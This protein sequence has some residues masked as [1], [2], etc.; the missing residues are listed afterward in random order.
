[1]KYSNIGVKNEKIKC[2]Q[3]KHSFTNYRSDLV[4][5]S[6]AF[7]ASIRSKSSMRSFSISTA[8]CLQMSSMHSSKKRNRLDEINHRG[9][10]D[11]SLD[12]E[13]MT[14]REDVDNLS[15]FSKML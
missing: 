15:D 4:A 12:A 2:H 5:V 8:K 13:E 10:R 14:T 3:K 7:C 11:E 9:G 1:M 6:R